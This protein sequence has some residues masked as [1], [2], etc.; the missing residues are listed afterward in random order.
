MDTKFGLLTFSTTH[1]AIS[2][3]ELLKSKQEFET[4]IISTPGKISAGC[5][6]SVRFNYSDKDAILKLLA[7]EDLQFQNIYVGTRVGVR[8]TYELDD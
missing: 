3:N 4:S 8:I 6:M 1:Q 7:D 2:T 5:G